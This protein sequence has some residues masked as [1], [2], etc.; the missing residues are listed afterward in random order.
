[1]ISCKEYYN[2]RLEEIKNTIANADCE[3][4]T[5]TIVQVGNNEA[6]NRY[7]R[8]KIKDCEKVG[9]KAKLVKY[10]DNVNLLSELLLMYNSTDGLILQLPLPDSM[11]ECIMKACIPPQMDVD[12]FNSSVTPCTPRGIMDWLHYNDISLDGKN[13]TIVGRS[14]LVGKP[15]AELMLKE[16][17]TVTLCHSHTLNLSEHFGNAD[18]IVSAVGKRGIIKD[19]DL[20]YRECPPVIIDVGINFNSNCKLCGDCEPN[21]KSISY[22]TPVPGGVGLLTRIAMLDNLI[23]LWNQH[24][25]L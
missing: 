14:E 17:A 23:D 24:H 19:E 4:P 11:N 6:S 10:D 22:Q 25:S 21:L 20:S 3:P 9:V 8:N 12:G 5:L 18:I 1:M 16:N 13:V 7:V 15:L 2:I